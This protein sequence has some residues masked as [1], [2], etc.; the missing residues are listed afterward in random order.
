MEIGMAQLVLGQIDESGAE[1]VATMY[2]DEVRATEAV[3]RKHSSV[4]PFLFVYYATLGGSTELHEMSLEQWTAFL[5][6]T[7]IASP[8]SNFSKSD[9]DRIFITVR[10]MHSCP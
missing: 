2:S 6:D 4:F 8:K 5:E 3:L 1:I 9:A 7:Q 10:A